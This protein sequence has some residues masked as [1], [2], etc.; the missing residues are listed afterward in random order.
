MKRKSS[1]AFT[2]IELLVVISIIAVLA[3]IALPVFTTVQERGA[4]TKDLSNAKQIAL[5]CKVF[6]GDN[7][8]KF[9]SL[10]GRAAEPPAGVPATSNAVLACLIPTYISTESTF[11]LPK[12]KWSP[13]PGDEKT[14]AFGDRLEAAT[15]NYAYVLGLSETDNPRYPLITDAPATGGTSA[16]WSTDPSVKGGV[17]KGKKAVVIRVD[18]SGAIETTVPGASGTQTI[19]K[20]QTGTGTVAD[21]FVPVSGAW[22]S[23]CTIL[24]PL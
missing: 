3:G 21:I 16:V 23:G 11:Y 4:Q 14:A 18:S 22:L 2:L 17:W 13:A 7:D 1:T 6:A 15:N 12:S 24:E 20:G 5:A 10:D 8:G 19:V 9:P